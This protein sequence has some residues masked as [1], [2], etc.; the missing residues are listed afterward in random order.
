MT[1]L[2]LTE[3]AEADLDEMWAYIAAENP[4]AADRMVDAVLE[5]SRMHARFPSMGQNR[6][7]LRPGLRCFVVLPFVIFYRPME[8]AIEVLRILHGAR[9]IGTIIKPEN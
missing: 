6:D 1:K 5:G 3:Q 8:D 4:L 2:R 7:D 9:D